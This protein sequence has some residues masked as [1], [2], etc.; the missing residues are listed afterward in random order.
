LL[1]PYGHCSKISDG[2]IKIGDKVR[3]LHDI[4]DAYMETYLSKNEIVKIKDIHLDYKGYEYELP[5]GFCIGRNEFIR[6]TNQR[7]RI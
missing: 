1:F 5:Y 4:K 3:L 2:G 7:K 6:I